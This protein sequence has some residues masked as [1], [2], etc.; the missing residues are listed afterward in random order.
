[1]LGRAASVFTLVSLISVQPSAPQ[2]RGQG[3]RDRTSARRRI[4]RCRPIRRSSGWRHPAPPGEPVAPVSSLPGRAAWNSTNRGSSP[5][6]CQ[7]SP[8]ARPRKRRSPTTRSIHRS[9]THPVVA[10]RRGA[11]ASRPAPEAVAGGISL[12]RGPAGRG[13]SGRRRGRSFRGGLLLRAGIARTVAGARRR[14]LT[15]GPRAGGGRGFGEGQSHVPP[16]PVPACADRFRAACRRRAPQ[17]GRRSAGQRNIQ[18]GLRPGGATVR[19][20]A[21]TPRR[22]RRFRRCSRSRRASRRKSRTCAS[23]RATS[24]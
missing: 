23:R 24:T 4:R 21:G 10:V 5:R 19:G 7:S 22:D 2:G 1:M 16:R 12:G 13:R 9:H 20:S 14:A 17:A 18:L 15:P 11:G 6:R 3:P 8:R